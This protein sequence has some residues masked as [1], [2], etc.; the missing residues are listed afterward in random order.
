VRLDYYPYQLNIYHRT[1]G[2][3]ALDLANAIWS[4]ALLQG[5]VGDGEQTTLLWQEA[6]CL[7]LSTK[8]QQGAAECD[9][10]LSQLK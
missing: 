3:S 9:H 6:R 1:E 8:V 4:M 5:S 7:Y 10:W 2:T